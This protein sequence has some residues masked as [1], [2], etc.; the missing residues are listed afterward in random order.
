MN[1]IKSNSGNTLFETVIYIGIFSMIFLTIS[2]FFIWTKIS[3]S[4]LQSIN[5]VTK[6]IDSALSTM[7]YEIRE[8]QEIYYP[9]SSSTQLSL[10]TYHYLPDNEE[11]SFVDIYLCDT[12]VCIK[13]EGEAAKKLTSDKVE[14]L[15]LQF[16]QVATSTAP[17]VYI[18]I[19]IRNAEYTPGKPDNYS[20][21]F[22]SVAT[23]RSI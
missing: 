14:V 13:R 19:I 17:S 5:Q 3:N 6:N 16:T 8:A 10:K 1:I 18:N 9:T 7:V 20:T 21:N 11:N 15:D 2:T 22:H 12:S 23:L 4:K